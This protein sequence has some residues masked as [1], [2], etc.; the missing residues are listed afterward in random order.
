RLRHRGIC[1][2]GI[3]AMTLVKRATK[4]TALTHAE[5]DGNFD[6][7][8]DRA[9]HTGTQAIS[10][11]TGLQGALDGKAGASHGHTLADISDAGTAAASAVGDLATA[12]QGAKADTAVQPADL[13]AF[14][15]A[16]SADTTAF[17]PA[18]HTSDT[19]NPHGVTAA[20]VGLGNVD[21]TADA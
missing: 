8:L 2:A 18:A 15:T 13:P 5:L 4:G 16:A 3:R 12:A 11:V 14:G 7:V 1:G 17:A 6:H 10:D 19:A 9:N 20:Q 21:N